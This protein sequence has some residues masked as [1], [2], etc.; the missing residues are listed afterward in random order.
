MTD[1]PAKKGG[2]P[3]NRVTGSLADQI[4]GLNVGDSVS[5][6]R[7]FPLDGLLDRDAILPVMNTTRTLM[8]ANAERAMD[9]VDA[10]DFKVESGLFITD[11]KSAIMGTVVVTRI[12]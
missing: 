6:S 8:C 9:E 4:N 3:R 5:V 1:A 7:R 2:R 11:D 10:R 12:S